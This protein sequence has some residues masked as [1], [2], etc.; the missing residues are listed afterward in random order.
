MK[1]WKLEA[2]CRGKPTDWFYETGG[3][4][5]PAQGAKSYL[6]ARPICAVCPVKGP[7]LQES[8]ETEA[9][10]DLRVRVPVHGF[11]AGMTPFERY[12][13]FSKGKKYR[14]YQEENV[15]PRPRDR[16]SERRKR[17]DPPKEW[18]LSDL[19]SGG[20]NH[21]VE[22]LKRPDVAVRRGVG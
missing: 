4:G 14:G 3:P 22:S 21:R 18:K 6:Q 5:R 15:R 8:R 20:P 17:P 7:C 16:V 19:D 9:L 10:A 1:D 12:K 2:A 13:V 11:R